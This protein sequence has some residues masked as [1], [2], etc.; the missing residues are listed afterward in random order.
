MCWTCGARKRCAVFAEL[1]R[2]GR[3]FNP[4]GRTCPR[5]RWPDTEGYIHTNHGA[6]L[7][8]PWYIRARI[9][10]QRAALAFRQAMGPD[11][12]PGCGCHAFL[13]ET[14][15]AF[16]GPPSFAPRVIDSRTFNYYREAT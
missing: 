7:G 12:L 10:A 15:D 14:W 1:T 16:F 8:V 3:A 11:F 13:R 2:D 5:G 6:Y 9:G 4:T